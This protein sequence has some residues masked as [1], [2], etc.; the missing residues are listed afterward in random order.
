MLLGVNFYG[1]E[2]SSGGGGS[3]GSGQWAAEPVKAERFLSVLARLQPEVRWD[4]AS[5]ENYIKFKEA[6]KRR[7]LWFP[8]PAA[9]SERVALARELGAGLSIWEIGQG[10]DALFDVL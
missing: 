9:L 10:M 6:G 8:T 1:Y 5:A 3:G 2:F 7:Q 4:A